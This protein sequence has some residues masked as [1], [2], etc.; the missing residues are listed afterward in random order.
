MV[1]LRPERLFPPYDSH[2]YAESAVCSEQR[3]CIQLG[4]IS[5][6][7]MRQLRLGMTGELRCVWD[8]RR[9]VK[10]GLGSCGA[11]WQFTRR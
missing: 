4:Q 1:G 2:R 3:V 8:S 5:E 9:G 11:P 7:L 10:T 6:A